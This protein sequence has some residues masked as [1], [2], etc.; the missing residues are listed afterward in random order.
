MAQTTIKSGLYGDN[1]IIH[2]KLENRYTASAAVG[3]TTGAQSID[4]SAACIFIMPGSLTGAIEFD[5]TN[6]KKGQIITIIGLTGSQTIT[7]DSDA[8]SSETFNKLSEVDY[9][10]SAT[11][12]IQIECI[13]DDATAIFNYVVSTYTSDATP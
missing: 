13:D 12:Q 6:Y 8:A 5:F 7:L 4:W 10:G 9:D 3:G 2:D 11:N 1:S